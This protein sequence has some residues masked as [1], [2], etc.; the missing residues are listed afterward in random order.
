MRND[1]QMV[2]DFNRQSHT[3]MRKR[4]VSRSESDYFFFHDVNR[5]LRLVSNLSSLLKKNKVVMHDEEAFK[6]VNHL[7]KVS[8]QMQ[9]LIS[10]FLFQKNDNRKMYCGEDIDLSNMICDSWC[11][12][13]ALNSDENPKLCINSKS[14]KIKGNKCFLQ[15]VFMNIFENAIRYKSVDDP[16]VTVNIQE[17]KGHVKVSI[18]DN[19]IGLRSHELE[20]VFMPRYR[21]LKS[22]HKSGHGLGLALSKQIV[23]LHNGEI[24]AEDSASRGACFVL[25]LPR[26]SS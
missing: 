12:T 1:S 11:K 5:M 18:T 16:K 9:E 23:K 20:K 22:D 2:S 25:R 17:E 10:F 13:Y 3:E 14:C 6:L 8:G 19:G 21:S 15:Q 24:W 7:G 26:V 4:D